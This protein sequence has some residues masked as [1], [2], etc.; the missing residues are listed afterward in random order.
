MKTKDEL[1]RKERAR[2]SKRTSEYISNAS[3]KIIDSLITSEEYKNAKSVFVYKSMNH[4]V[5]TE[6]LLRKAFEDKKMIYV[7][8]LVGGNILPI[9]VN[10]F[11]EYEVDKY[12]ISEPINGDCAENL[13]LCILPMMAFDRNKS[14]LGHGSGYY[15]KFLSDF[16]GVKIGLAFSEQEE[17]VVPMNKHDI[18][19]DIIITEKEI[20]K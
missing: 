14:R 18:Y 1:R 20:I 17:D 4:E 8:R 2:I 6:M 9:Q 16:N 19:M 7:P 11:T 13:D 3:S 15:D 10:Q 12:G 5:D